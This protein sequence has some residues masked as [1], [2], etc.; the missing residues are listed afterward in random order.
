MYCQ[1][2]SRAIVH[3]TLLTHYQ[4]GQV[5]SKKLICDYFGIS[6][7]LLVRF[8]LVTFL[9][10]SM[11]LPNNVMAKTSPAPLPQ[12]IATPKLNTALQAELLA[13]QQAMIKFQQEKM[14]YANGKLPIELIDKI[15]EVNKNNSLRLQEIIK[16][17]GWPTTN[18][19]GIKGR[20][21][22]FILLQQAEQSVQERLLPTLKN[23]FAQGQMSGQKLSS[24][25]DI[26]LIKSG[27]KQRY[28]TQLA[29]VNGKIV[30]NDIAEKSSLD[31]RRQEMNMLPMAQY[32]VLLKKMYQ[33][34]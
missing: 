12:T 34:D 3:K 18:V 2:L 33:L 14:S 11:L 22:A 26:M 17:E 30:F 16:K 7:F 27:K 28:G 6:N 32:K 9:L 24:F 29:I 13:M 20:E 1:V 4:Y 8:L 23:E 15:A 25:I 31:L 19:V 21:A 5:L 10:F